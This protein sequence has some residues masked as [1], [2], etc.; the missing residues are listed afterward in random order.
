MSHPDY[1]KKQTTV[2]RLFSFF[3]HVEKQI[4]M[5]LHEQDYNLEYYLVS[6]SEDFPY[7][8]TKDV[9]I[10]LMLSVF[11]LDLHQALHLLVPEI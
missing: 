3:Q 4:L 9:C 1:A 10:V 11:S 5:N 6:Y 7:L 8:Q 2:N